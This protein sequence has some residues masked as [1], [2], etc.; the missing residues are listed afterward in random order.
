MS[1]LPDDALLS[2]QELSEA[3]ANILNLPVSAATLE[4]KRCRG[5]GPPYE[6]FSRTVRY[7][8]GTARKWR[9]AQ[10]TSDKGASATAPP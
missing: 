3:F 5:G 8:W 7:R 6:K 2:T 1:Q 10:G 4:T 9:L